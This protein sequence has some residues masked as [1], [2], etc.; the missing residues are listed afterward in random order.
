MSSYYTVI[1]LKTFLVR[2]GAGGGGGGIGAC[3]SFYHATNE[4]P[5]GVLWVIGNRGAANDIDFAE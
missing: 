4:S 3:G 5:Q 1:H 2:G